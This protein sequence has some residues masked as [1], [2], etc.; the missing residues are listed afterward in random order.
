MCDWLQLLYILPLPPKLGQKL[1]NGDKGGLY[2]FTSS[3][4]IWDVRVLIYC[5]CSTLQHIVFE[6]SYL[7]QEEP[8]RRLHPW[9]VGQ[10][11]N[12]RRTNYGLQKEI[13]GL[14]II[15]D[16]QFHSKITTIYELPSF[17]VSWQSPSAC[18]C[19]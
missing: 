18:E 1:Q 15:C 11:Q 7:F 14:Q 6:K 19:A 4:L 3:W 2:S 13:W 17:L 12:C 8:H 9:I 16:S 5:S 10:Y